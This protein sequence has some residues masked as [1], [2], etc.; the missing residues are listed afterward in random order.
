M[1]VCVT[2]GS[3]YIGTSLINLLLSKGC[4]V[5]ALIHNRPLADRLAKHPSLESHVCDLRE[6]SDLSPFLKGADCLIHNA[7][8]WDEKPLHTNTLDKF[9]SINLF[10]WAASQGVG[11]ILYTSS[12]AVHRP[13]TPLMTEVDDLQPAD[14][15]AE[16]K[17]KGELAAKDFAL[18]AGIKTTIIRAAPVIGPPE[19][20]G[21]KMKMLSTMKDIFNAALDNATI[22]LP[23][24]P[25]RQ[26]ISRDDLAQTFWRAMQPDSPPGTYLAASSNYTTWESIAR[27]FLEQLGSKSS[28]VVPSSLSQPCHFDCSRLE[29]QLGL[30]F[31]SHAGLQAMIESLTADYTKGPFSQ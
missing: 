21:E 12:T 23:Y 4:Q 31:N 15:Y 3:G 6:L 17:L 5:T 25:G 13:F 18:Q 1:R 11:H 2:G 30:K 27:M 7:I 24:E 9:V 14:D 22:H 28:I 26:F 10:Q 20:E 19:Y 8:V 16:T 29:D